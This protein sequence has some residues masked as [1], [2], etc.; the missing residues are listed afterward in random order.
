MGKVEIKWEDGKLRVFSPAKGKW[1]S[2][3]DQGLLSL[4]EEKELCSLLAEEFFDFLGEEKK[5]RR[6]SLLCS[7]P[8][9]ETSLCF[10]AGSF[11][12]WHLGH[13]ACLDLC[14]H[15]NIIVMPD[16]NPW[17]SFVQRE[18]P[19]FDFLHLVQ[20]FKGSP[21]S[22]YPGF[23]ARTEANP[24]INWLSQ[25]KAPDK[26]L[27]MGDDTFLDLHRWTR[28]DEVLKLLKG[29]YIAPRLVSDKDKTQQKEVLLKMNPNL[30]IH[31]LNHH[32][33]EDLSSSKIRNNS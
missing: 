1:I 7:F 26:Y 4:S 29:I 22:F 27:L 31:F 15:P 23:L 11:F 25:V 20:H 24:S 17:K 12:P 33:F 13:Q 28:G 14:P 9:Q 16:L 30:E 8:V 21:W 32:D 5:E 19:F 2:E 6:P 3:R 10:F 18:H